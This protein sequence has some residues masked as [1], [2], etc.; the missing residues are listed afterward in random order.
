LGG[1]LRG[2]GVPFT[3]RK[4]NTDHPDKIIP[5]KIRGIEIYRFDEVITIFGKFSNSSI[6][7]EIQIKNIVN[8]PK[9]IAPIGVRIVR[10]FL[11][12]V[13]VLYRKLIHKA[14]N[15]M[16]FPPLLSMGWRDPQILC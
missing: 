16:I 3:L 2:T 7:R 4:C 10:T 8:N 6:L 12:P 9:I 15:P 14:F 1:G 5:R 11:V 13:A